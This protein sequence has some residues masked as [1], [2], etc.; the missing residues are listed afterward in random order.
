MN[1]SELL[2]WMYVLFIPAV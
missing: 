2:M 1:A